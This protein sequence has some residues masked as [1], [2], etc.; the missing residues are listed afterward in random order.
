MPE[1]VEAVLR[2]AQHGGIAGVAITH[3]HPD[4]D[5]AAG[6][7]AERAGGVPVVRPSGG[8]RVGPFEAVATPGH[9]PDHV[10]LVWGRVCFTGDTVLGE[11]SV[12]VGAG[13]GSVADYLDSLRRLRSLE[14]DVLCPGHGPFAW[15]PRGRI[16]FYLE[17]RLERERLIL[18]AIEA[19]ARTHDEILDR[20]WSDTDLTVHPMLRWAALQTLLAHLVK[21]SDEGRLPPEVSTSGFGGG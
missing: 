15:D 8:D 3:G 10:A 21:L 12:F 11:G 2:A 20:A 4:H 7:L 18:D 16:D 14:L 19:G 6:V 13:G 9:A 17:H 5:E 1:H